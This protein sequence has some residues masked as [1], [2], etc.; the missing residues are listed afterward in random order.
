MTSALSRI[1]RSSRTSRPPNAATF[2]GSQSRIQLN[3]QA[4]KLTHHR[5][6]RPEQMQLQVADDPEEAGFVD[7]TGHISSGV[8]EELQEFIDCC[9]TGSQ[10]LVDGQA[11]KM[12]VAVCLAAQESIQRGEMVTIEEILD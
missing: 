2:L 3:N 4:Q 10:P 1:S 9:R 5:F 6:D 11:G 8:Y 7:A 12:G